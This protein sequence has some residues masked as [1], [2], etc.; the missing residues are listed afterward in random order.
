MTHPTLTRRDIVVEISNDTGLV[1][2]EV[3]DIVTRT[4]DLIIR[5]LSEGKDVELRNFGTFEVRMSKERL[6]RNP[7]DP[8]NNL[9]I[10]SRAQ[11]RFKS[12]KAMR[13]EIERKKGRAPSRSSPKPEI[14]QAA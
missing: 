11:V 2:H 4:L 14:A 6:G 10:P 12:G 8:D 13:Q 7:N 3:C 5:S 9:I 1:Q